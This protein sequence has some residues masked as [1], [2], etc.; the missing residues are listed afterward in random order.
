M[1]KQEK[2]TNAHARRIEP[3]QHKNLANLHVCSYQASIQRVHTNVQ[4][5]RHIHAHIQSVLPS[6]QHVHAKQDISIQKFKQNKV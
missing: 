3:Q 6:L 5:V 1:Q 4:R 2:G